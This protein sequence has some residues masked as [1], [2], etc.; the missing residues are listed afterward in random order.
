MIK[1]IAHAAYTVSDMD[2]AMAFYVDGLGLKKAFSLADDQGRPWIEYLKVCDGQFIELFYAGED[3]CARNGSYS[4]LCLE[5]DDCATTA[6][7]LEGR[8]VKIVVPPQQG[9]DRNWQCWVAD[10]DGNRIEIMQIDPSAPQ[11]NA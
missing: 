4:H 2:K 1:G 9:K 8:G 11:A 5:V 3:F 10:P 7:E 6:A